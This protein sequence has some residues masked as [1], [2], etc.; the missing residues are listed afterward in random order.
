MVVVNFK[1]QIADT[2]CCK[3]SNPKVQRDYFQ[4]M[5]TVMQR[6]TPR[7]PDPHQYNYVNYQVGTATRDI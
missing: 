5:E 7:K 2:I 1:E 4:A 3:A 6:I